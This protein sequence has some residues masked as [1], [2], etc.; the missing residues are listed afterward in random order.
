MRVGRILETCLYVNDLE[1]ARLFYCDVLG[2]E[3]ESS[4][5][6]R[7]LFLKCGEAMLL[8]F[9]PKISSR[10]DSDFPIHGSVGPG[11]VAFATGH[12]ELAQWR[13]VLDRHRVPIERDLT[14][15]GGGR[16]IY[17]RDP[18]G[19]SVELATPDIWGFGIE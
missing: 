3:F 15:P 1:A 8:L 14:W 5:P 19:N 18:A 16:S 7:H 11:H 9:D 17:F 12:Q 2:L 10:S 13:S 4:Q 6:G